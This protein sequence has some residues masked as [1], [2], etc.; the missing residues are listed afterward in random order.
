M[1]SRKVLPIILCAGQQSRH[2]HKEQAFGLSG[3]SR[4]WDDLR[5]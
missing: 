3:R 5:E 4:G 1:K 2:R